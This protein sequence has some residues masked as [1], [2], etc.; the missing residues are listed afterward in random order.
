MDTNTVLWAIDDDPYDVS[1]GSDG[2]VWSYE[3]CAAKKGPTLISPF[4]GAVIDCDDCFCQSEPFTLKWERLCLGCSWDIEIMDEAGNLIESIYVETEG[5]TPE[6][7]FDGSVIEACGETYTWHVRLADTDCECVKSPWSETWSFTV[8]AGIGTGVELISPLFGNP[9]QG[10]NLTNVPFTWTAV[11][12]ADS[13]SMVLSAFSNL[14]AALAS[15]DTVGTAYTYTGMLEYD[16]AYYWQV[17][18]WKDSAIISTSDIGAFTTMKRAVEPPPPVVVEP[19]PPPVINIP[20]AQQITPVWIYAIIGIGA[21][22]A[23][24]VIVL[25]VR[26]RRP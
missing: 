26:T 8:A 13:Y 20:P 2:T 25:I 21:A 15:I 17:T 10:T 12:D 24:V 22:L 6:E 5:E 18:A 23:I 14:S 16:T 11:A 9:D 7:Y 1:D 4:D 3:D 19:T